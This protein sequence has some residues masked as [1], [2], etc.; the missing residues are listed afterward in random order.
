MV[1]RCRFHGIRIHLVWQH[2]SSQKK[3][4]LRRCIECKIVNKSVDKKPQ[5]RN[6]IENVCQRNL[7]LLKEKKCSSITEIE[8]NNWQWAL[9]MNAKDRLS[10]YVF[11]CLAFMWNLK[12][13][14]SSKWMCALYTYLVCCFFWRAAEWEGHLNYN[15]IA[16]CRLSSFPILAMP[17]FANNK[18]WTPMKGRKK[19]VVCTHRLE[20]ENAKVYLIHFIAGEWN[21]RWDDGE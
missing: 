10:F 2:A 13:I 17:L 12:R 3:R 20:N 9:N 7:P 5:R 6:C 4:N 11:V 18:K 15:N 1:H 14:E 21:V 16:R 8:T 19:A